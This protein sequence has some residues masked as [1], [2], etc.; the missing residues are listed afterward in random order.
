MYT[1]LR[2]QKKIA[3]L[4]SYDYP[5]HDRQ[6]ISSIPVS[7]CIERK[8]IQNYKLVKDV[9]KYII[10]RILQTKSMKT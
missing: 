4:G 8:K 1:V 3:L 10:I 6:R 5:V 2:T 7:G 9:N